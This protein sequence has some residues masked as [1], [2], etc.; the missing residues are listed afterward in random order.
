LRPQS[1]RN[2]EGKRRAG[3]YGIRADAH[4]RRRY[5]VWADAHE[6]RRYGVWADA[7]E[8]VFSLKRDGAGIPAKRSK[9]A[10]AHTRFAYRGV[11][12]TGWVGEV[13]PARILFA[14]RG[15]R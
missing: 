1:G 4:E 10:L 5:G 8:L 12:V 15:W 3:R 13:R 9:C 14:F 2:H 11:A 6:R 7:H